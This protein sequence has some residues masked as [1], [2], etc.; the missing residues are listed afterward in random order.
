M[1]ECA[2]L[3]TDR[4]GALQVLPDG[5]RLQIT[6]FVACPGVINTALSV[7]WGDESARSSPKP[8]EEI[9][10]L[11]RPAIHDFFCTEQ[12]KRSGRVA[13][14]FCGG[15]A[16]YKE[17]HGTS[18]LFKRCPVPQLEFMRFA[19]HHDG[20]KHRE[21]NDQNRSGD[22]RARGNSRA[23]SQHGTAQV[24]RISCVSVWTGDGEN[25]LLVKI[26]SSVS[27]HQQTSNAY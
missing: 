13:R 26:A 2:Y 19:P 6:C 10:S 12:G 4:D 25:F 11:A 27:T 22:P 16:R 15:Q 20:I 7:T 18:V 5:T 21:I 8:R 17:R 1:R 9:R 23:Q 24:E 14:Q 3:R